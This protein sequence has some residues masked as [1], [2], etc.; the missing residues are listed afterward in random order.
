MAEIP[1]EWGKVQMKQFFDEQVGSVKSVKL[2]GDDD[3][4]THLNLGFVEFDAMHHA[5][6]AVERTNGTPVGENRH[7]LIVKLSNDFYETNQ[8]HSNQLSI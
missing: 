7:P 3:G 6:I 8:S 5:V 1:S 4:C 2:I